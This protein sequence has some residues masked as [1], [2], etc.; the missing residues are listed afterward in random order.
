MAATIDI[1]G[2]GGSV[3]TV[4][5]EAESVRKLELMKEMSESLAGRISIVELTGLSLREIKGIP[6][7]SHFVPTEEYLQ[8]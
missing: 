6:F 8:E 4:V 5:P 3:H 2:V 1:Y 7:S